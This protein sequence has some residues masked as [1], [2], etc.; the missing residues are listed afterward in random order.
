MKCYSA[1]DK[2]VTNH[3]LKLKTMVPLGI[4]RNMYDETFHNRECIAGDLIGCG[5]WKLA[6][7]WAS[8]S[9]E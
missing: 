6:K 2:F 1:G 4:Q 8:W 3:I 7:G 5:L 9:P